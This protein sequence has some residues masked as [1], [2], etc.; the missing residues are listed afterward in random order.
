MFDK[1]ISTA[2]RSAPHGAE[3]RRNQTTLDVAVFWIA[4]VGSAVLTVIARRVELLPGEVSTMQWIGTHLSGSLSVAGPVLDMAFTDLMP[5]ALFAML[6]VV[7][8]WRWG[9]YP[10]AL[11]FV[12]GSVTGLTKVADLARRPRPND[13]LTW[14]EIVVGEGGYPSGHVVYTVMVFGTLAYLASRHVDRRAPRHLLQAGAV[15]LIVVTGPSRLIEGDHWP[16]DVVA[17]YV[18]ASA[19]LAA[20]VWIDRYVPDALGERAP[21]VHRWLHLDRDPVG[22]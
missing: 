15:L 3:R 1:D 11:L 16:L 18:I 13:D 10:A 20:V 14:G 21:R 22:E 6:V 4:I 9:R 19:G 2:S 17:G 8:W 5:P 7:V 12:A